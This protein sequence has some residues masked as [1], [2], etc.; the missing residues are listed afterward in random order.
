MAL[1][2]VLE[3]S[4]T[5]VGVYTIKTELECVRSIPLTTHILINL[6]ALQHTI[7]LINNKL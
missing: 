3:P 6:A 7:V 4:V 5:T 1:L 2:T